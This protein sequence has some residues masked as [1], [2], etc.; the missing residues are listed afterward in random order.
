[1]QKRIVYF[2]SESTGITASYL[3]KSLLPQFPDFTFERHFAS[4]VNTPEL[5]HKLLAEWDALKEA[6]EQ[7]PLVFATMADTEINDLLQQGYCH[8]YEFF[9]T[10]IARLEDDLGGKALHR[11]GLSHGLKNQRVYDESI[12]IINFA[13]NHDDAIKLKGLEEADVILVGVSRSGKTPTCLYLALHYRIRA[14]NYPLT[15]DDFD[16]GDIPDVL[17]KHKDKLVALR[18]TPERLS[19]IRQKRR[20]G[21]QYASLAQCRAE[22]RQADQFFQRYRLPVLNTTSSSIEELASMIVSERHLESNNF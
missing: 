15:D 12:D 18:I 3:A 19:A 20:P 22:V 9:N 5:A 4:Y 21:S 17:K 2:V 14:A 8:Y 16:R 11:S 6:G 13:L 1:M 10:F 7:A